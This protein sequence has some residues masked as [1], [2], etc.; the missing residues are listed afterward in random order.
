MHI[1]KVLGT[2]DS[3]WLSKEDILLRFPNG[4]SRAL[5][6]SHD[7]EIT[8][9]EVFKFVRQDPEAFKEL[10]SMV[11]KYVKP[12]RVHLEDLAKHVNMSPAQT[13][14][15]Y[16]RKGI[17][18]GP[19]G[20]KITDLNANAFDLYMDEIFS[21]LSGY[22]DP[23][24]VTGFSLSEKKATALFNEYKNLLGRLTEKRGHNSDVT[25]DLRYIEL[26]Y[27]GSESSPLKF[28]DDLAAKVWKDFPKASSHLHIGLPAELSSQKLIAISRAVEMKIILSM[29]TVAPASEA[30]KL[31]FSMYSTLI[32]R[33]NLDFG[34]D[35]IG[36]RGVIKVSK[37][38]FQK[39]Y[40]AHDLEIRQY[41]SHKEGLA[42]LELAAKLAK[43]HDQLR[44]TKLDTALPKQSE[45]AE[46]RYT[47]NLYGALAYAKTL[48]SLR[49]QSEDLSLVTK[50]ESI[51]KNVD[52][53]NSTFSMDHR[54]LVAKLLGS[55]NL[56]EVFG[57]DLFLKP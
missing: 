55:I 5:R 45:W 26:I 4:E 14:A 38:R 15:F 50:I 41:N 19:D 12:F 27:K 31:S 39:P 7:S 46:D 6:F 17:E 13:K 42:H 21:P 30:E 16:I 22:S 10:E 1:K 23:P 29:A 25:Q 11:E 43:S 3:I 53:N 28:T 40:P 36:S 51:L 48:L 57:E 34:R 54:K 32:K 47:T 9:A 49:G 24:K 20:Y 37:N 18:A 8:H 2:Q 44:L 52:E 33:P 35:Y 56:D